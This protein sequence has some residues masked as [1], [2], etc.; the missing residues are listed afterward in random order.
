M[1]PHIFWVFG[2]WKLCINYIWY[3]KF[4]VFLGIKPIKCKYSIYIYIYIKEP[5]DENII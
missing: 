4:R 2:L 3:S 1:E 5:N